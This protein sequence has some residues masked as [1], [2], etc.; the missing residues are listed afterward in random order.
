MKPFVLNISLQ[1]NYF[2][3]LLHLKIKDV[4]LILSLE[5]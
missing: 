1:V 5:M 3:V 4:G 2:I